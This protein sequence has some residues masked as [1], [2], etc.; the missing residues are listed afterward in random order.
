MTSRASRRW[1]RCGRTQCGR[2]S[3]ASWPRRASSTPAC[4]R[5]S[6]DMLR[7]ITCSGSRCASAAIT[8][9]RSRSSW[10]PSPSLRAL[11]TPEWP[12]PGP[13]QATGD[14][15]AAA[16][17]C[18]EGF[19]ATVEPSAAASRTRAR[20]ARRARRPG[21]GGGLRHRARVRSRRR[22]D[23]LQ[24]RRRAAD[25][26][27]AGRR[28]RVHTGA[29]WRLAA[30]PRPRPISIS[31]CCSRNRAPRRRRSPP[32]KT[33]SRASPTNA[34]AYK[35]LGEVLQAAGRIDAW[36]ANFDRFEAHCPEALALAVQ[37]LEVLPAP[38]RLR[39]DSTAISTVCAPGAFARDDRDS[40]CATT[41]S[42]SCTCC[43]S[44]T[45]SRRLIFRYRA[46]VRRRGAA[47]VRRA[48]RACRPRAG[49]AAC[50]SAIS[51]PTCAIT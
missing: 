5:S 2:I 27:P 42:S 39:R 18:G 36:F 48:A 16:D 22:R 15:R 14:P 41:S 19:P 7:R 51:P 33:C 1:R 12:W 25:A 3:E 6:R 20:A 9:V 37:A 46:D 47:R 44:S 11:S 32:T 49:R 10:R 13:L 4:L 35:N 26:A 50:A 43:S 40:S 8:P 28:R 17:V 30:G 21:R 31:A 24:P 23:A 34:A 38:R 29:R 45:S